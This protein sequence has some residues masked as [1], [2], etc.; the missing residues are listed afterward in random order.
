ML[1]STVFNTLSQEIS[2]KVSSNSFGTAIR[3]CINLPK[4]FK[5]RKE[6]YA[7]GRN[8][9][10]VAVKFQE[11]KLYNHTII[12][13]AKDIDTG[14]KSCFRNSINKLKVVDDYNQ[15]MGDIN[16]NDAVV[17]HYSCI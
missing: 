11:K 1:Q 2:F 10:L 7:F 12:Q 13:P 14:K 4:L 5:D 15:M 9:N 17:N 8:G 3:S 6:R 16:K